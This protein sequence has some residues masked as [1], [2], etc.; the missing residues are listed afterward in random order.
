M[1]KPIDKIKTL[2]QRRGL[3]S[4]TQYF[5][6]NE[7]RKLFHE[8]NPASFLAVD[9]DGIPRLPIMD[10]NENL[11]YPVLKQSLL[12]VNVKLRSHPSNIDLL[13]SKSILEEQISRFDKVIHKDTVDIFFQEKK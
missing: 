11:S 1:L 3:K 6:D 12:S 8:N 4:S 9:A 2:L 10:C 5:S 7:N 13:R